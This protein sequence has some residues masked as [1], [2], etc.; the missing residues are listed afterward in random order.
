VKYYKYNSSALI[1]RTGRDEM[2][3]RILKFLPHALSCQ[4]FVYGKQRDYEKALG[5]L[6]QLEEGRKTV[7]LA[8]VSSWHYALVYAGM[9]RTEQALDALDRAFEERCDWLIHAGVEPR[10]KE[11]RDE[12]RFRNLLSRVGVMV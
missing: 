5:C 12:E 2:K 10:W 6:N 3:I 8:Y 4:G 11:I 9:G 7:P 1:G